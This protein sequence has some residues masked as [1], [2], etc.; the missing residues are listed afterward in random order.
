MDHSLLAIWLGVSKQ[1]LDSSLPLRFSDTS[2][3]TSCAPAWLL[4]PA[5]SC[6]MLFVC[7]RSPAGVSRAHQP[8]G[9]GAQILLPEFRD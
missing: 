4:I 5:G 8:G 9:P 1:I 2:M 6:N 7:H 3:H